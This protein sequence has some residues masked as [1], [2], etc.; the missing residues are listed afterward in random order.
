MIF[1]LTSSE[2]A[3]LW[4]G[5]S[6]LT[7]GGRGKGKKRLLIK[8]YTGNTSLYLSIL[9]L[10]SLFLHLSGIRNPQDTRLEF[11]LMGGGISLLAVAFGF[12]VLGKYVLKKPEVAVFQVA[13][14]NLSNSGG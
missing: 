5:I 9:V 8:P 7:T 11:W 12:F 6:F 2:L 1:W 14:Y 10:T 4:P 3:W 13:V